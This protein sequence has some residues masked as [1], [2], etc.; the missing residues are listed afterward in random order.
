MA[1]E[2]QAAFLSISPGDILSKFV[3]ESE[4][5]VRSLFKRAEE[6][7]C[8][9]ESKCAV[10]FFDE[11]DALGQSRENNNSNNRGGGI[12]GGGE[13]GAGGEGRSRTLLAELLVQLSHIAQRN[14]ERGR[15]R[16]RAT[17]SSSDEEDASA[18]NYSAGQGG[19]DRSIDSRATNAVDSHPPQVLIIA[20]T[21]RP[22]DCDPALLRRFG[23][24]VHVGLPSKRDRAKL[25]RRHLNDFEHAIT[26]ADLLGIA[27]ATE[28]WSPCDLESL[29]REA[30]MAPVRECVRAAALQKKRQRRTQRRRLQQT[31]GDISGPEEDQATAAGG[32]DQEVRN[33][34]L[35]S[36]Q[37][38]RPVTTDDFERAAAFYLGQQDQQSSSSS[39][40]GGTQ[41]NIGNNNGK[42]YGP[43]SNNKPRQPHY[44]SSS[45]EDDM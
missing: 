26:D 13:G 21:N 18:V 32:G 36:F 8:Q 20:A 15:G 16:G 38:L 7:A 6:Y 42:V 40:P 29:A 34:L 4:A 25:L 22:D 3:G 39:S 44:D 24:R 11:I 41:S 12:D 23:V 27:E 14:K 17:D 45:D 30:A 10:I 33:S 31:E 28:G 19:D 43:L 37:S 1:G 9:V 5:A 2:A 35:A